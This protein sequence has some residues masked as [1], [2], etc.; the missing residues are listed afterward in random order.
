MSPREE[1]RSKGEKRSQGRAVLIGALVSVKPEPPTLWATHTNPK[2]P[3]S[4]P[5]CLHFHWEPWKPSNFLRQKCELRYQPQL[6]E[7]SWTRVL[8]QETPEPEV[9]GWRVGGTEAHPTR[10]HRPRFRV[11]PPT[12]TFQMAPLR[13][14]D[15]LYELCGLLPATTYAL[16]MRCTRWPLPGHWSEWSPSLKLRTT[17]GGKW[18]TKDWAQP[19]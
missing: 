3:S 12:C 13:S 17:Q 14:T 6:K 15:L 4:Q 16:Q 5:D 7:A 10:A 19:F 2:R 18:P 8:H 9:G 11:A 1:N